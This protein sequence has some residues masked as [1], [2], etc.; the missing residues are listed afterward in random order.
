M[1]VSRSSP[2]EDLHWAD[3]ASWE[4][5]F[6]TAR[7]VVKMPMALLVTMRQEE[8]QFDRPW[9]QRLATFRREEDVVE[10]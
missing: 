6:Y 9:V 2:L 8:L 1:P 10:V 7:R 3:P 5:A 4:F